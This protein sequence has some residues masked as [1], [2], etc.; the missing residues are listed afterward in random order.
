MFSSSSGHHV[1]SVNC[2]FAGAE[3]KNRDN[4]QSNANELSSDVY[5]D[6]DISVKERLARAEAVST[7]LC[8]LISFSLIFFYR[9]GMLFQRKIQSFW[10]S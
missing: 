3:I 10:L 7:L 5:G 8:S 9:L 2:L 1:L 4:R 6:D